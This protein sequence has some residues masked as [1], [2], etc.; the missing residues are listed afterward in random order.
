M[1]EAIAMVS[2]VMAAKVRFRRGGLLQILGRTEEAVG[3][4]RRAAHDLRD[5]DPVWRARALITLANTLVDYGDAR[6]AGEALTRAE[7]A[8][9]GAGPVFEAA[10]ARCN[11]GLVAALLGQ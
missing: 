5:A 2:G 1:D 7:A 6:A 11:R 3:E 4:L 10:V 8:L 9:E